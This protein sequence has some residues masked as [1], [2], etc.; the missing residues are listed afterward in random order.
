M[1]LVIVVRFFLKRRNPEQRGGFIAFF[2][3]NMFDTSFFFPAITGLMMVTA[4]SPRE[5][6]A[7]LC[8][9]PVKI[10]AGAFALGLAALALCYALGI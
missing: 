4:G 9:T 2:V 8:G 5:T 3:H 1:L 10:L 6:G 7:C